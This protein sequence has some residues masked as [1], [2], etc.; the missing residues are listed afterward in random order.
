MTNDQGGIRLE[1]IDVPMDYEAVFASQLKVIAQLIYE[2][3]YFRGAKE[4]QEDVGVSAQHYSK[5]ALDFTVRSSHANS[6]VVEYP[7]RKV[8]IDFTNPE[9]ILN[10]VVD[11]QESPIEADPAGTFILTDI[12]RKLVEIELDGLNL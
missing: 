7:E 9:V 12:Q 6:L 2:F 10:M 4:G 11:K 1:A 3:R 5:D 8:V